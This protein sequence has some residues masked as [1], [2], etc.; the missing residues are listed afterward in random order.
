[1]GAYHRA[2]RLLRAAGVEGKFY[3]IT[4]R[5]NLRSIL[6]HG[7]D[8][9]KSEKGMVYLS[10]DLGHVRAYAGSHFG[11][12]ASV[13]LEVDAA[14][15]DAGLLGPD[16]DDLQDMLE[17]EGDGRDWRDVPWDESVR[18]TGQCA[19]RGRIPPQA[20][21]ALPDDDV[22]PPV[23]RR[24][25][26]R[27]PWDVTLGELDAMFPRA[28]GAVDGRAVRGGEVPN[29]GSV[30]ASMENSTVLEGVRK[31]P[32]SAF[33][34]GPPEFYS[35]G[36][37]ERT[38]SLAGEIGES[39]EVAPLIVA[40]DDEGPYVLEGSH[41][42]DALR[43]LGAR[44]FPALVALDEGALHSAV[45]SALRAGEPVRPEVL[46]EYPDL[47]NGA[48]RRAGLSKL[49][50]FSSCVNWPEGLLPALGL[51]I[52]EGKEIGKRE[53]LS[54]ADADPNEFPRMYHS[55]FRYFRQGRDVYWFTHSA[56]E[57]VFAERESIRAVQRAAEA[58]QASQASGPE[59]ARS[60]SPRIQ[61]ESQFIA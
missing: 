27:Q 10:P 29:T 36:E 56:I 37:M 8:P 28:G 40:Y 7:L 50:Y 4:R 53:F 26:A 9:E 15:L 34:P 17:Q 32:M 21:R 61:P 20:L 16:D 24:A 60:A 38:T 19:Y 18:M 44:S 48:R 59:A 52:D 5:R 45:E 1:M 39:G 33:G 30:D 14:M 54:R 3:H 31:V 57:H 22:P 23:A 51:L 58:A 11:G 41:R 42:F 49:P 25:A 55:D 12:D 35:K 6:E 43:L 2:A 46:G 47:A 13:V